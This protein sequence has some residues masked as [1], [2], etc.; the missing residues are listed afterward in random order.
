M[1][2]CCLLFIFIAFLFHIGDENTLSQYYIFSFDQFKTIKIIVKWRRRK[3][4]NFYKDERGDAEKSPYIVYTVGIR[5]EWQAHLSGRSI[6]FAFD[7]HWRLHI[8]MFFSRFFLHLYYI[9][10]F[11]HDCNSIAIVN[12]KKDVDIWKNLPLWRVMSINW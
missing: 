12:A 1:F 10:S 11:L 6:F 2:T 5:H 9:C 4:T 7:V 8:E 3:K